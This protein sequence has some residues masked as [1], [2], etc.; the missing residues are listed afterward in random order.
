MLAGCAAAPAPDLRPSV[1]ELLTGQS[2]AV[3]RRA[4]VEIATDGFDKVVPR[5]GVELVGT[6]V[7]VA[8]KKGQ[9]NYKVHDGYRYKCWAESNWVLAWSG[10]FW[11]GH[12]AVAAN[13][14]RTCGEAKW[15]A[16]NLPPRSGLSTQDDGARGC[17]TA[18]DVLS[19]WGTVEGLD[20]TNL[21]ISF[22]W[23]DTDA[24]HV[25][26]PLTPQQVVEAVSPYDWY[27]IVTV[28]SVYYQDEP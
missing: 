19:A 27:A 12:D 5:E 18:T 11:I 10:D 14:D 17:S 4:A 16:N 25:I 24:F 9:N 13:L 6:R 7:E 21:D 1:D 8:C 26:D 28:Q 15:S 20:D 2:E 3:E 23:F 22:K